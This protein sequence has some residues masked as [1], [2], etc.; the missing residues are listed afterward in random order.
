MLRCGTSIFDLGDA[1]RQVTLIYALSPVFIVSLCLVFER[2]GEITV[3]S[4]VVCLGTVS[5]DP[6]QKLVYK[7]LDE[8]NYKN[9]KC[10]AHMANYKACKQFWMDV[11]KDRTKNG[12]SPGLPWPE[13]RSRVKEE[14]LKKWKLNVPNR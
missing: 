14:Y 7:C 5:P 1:D 4:V 8:N 9:D 3:S 11:R 10:I 12:I 13:D 6:E 2:Y